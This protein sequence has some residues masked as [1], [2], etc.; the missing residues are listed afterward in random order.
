MLIEP[1][2]L[3]GRRVR[4]DPLTLGHLDSLCDFALDKALWR[5][6][7]YTVNTRADL[8][9]YIRSL[10]EAQRA[11]TSL[12]FVTVE[13][14]SAH[15]VGFTRYMN[16]DRLNRRTEIGGTVIAPEWQRTFVNTE[17]KYLMLEHAFEQWRCVRVEFKADSLNQPSRNA[18]LRLGAK[19]E[20][21]FRNHMI[22][23]D[24]RLRHSV[25]FSII[26]SEWPHVKQHLT[27]KLQPRV[28]S[29]T[30]AT[31]QPLNSAK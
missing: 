30:T 24:G 3:E 7:P 20:G 28:A 8:E 19:E 13:R 31:V 10:L 9:A 15:A 21:V 23:P 12:P 29:S 17:A 5:W 4:L 26:N 22:M 18:I 1:V 14:A 25:Y 27:A 6:M 11:G 2:T 16:I